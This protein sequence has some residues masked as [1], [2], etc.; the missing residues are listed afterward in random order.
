MIDLILKGLYLCCKVDSKY[1]KSSQYIE[2]TFPGKIFAFDMIE[3]KKDM[4][5]I[6]AINYFSRFVFAKVLNLKYLKK[7]LAFIKEV[8]QNI[9]FKKLI[10]DNGKEFNNSRLKKWSRENDVKLE[11]SIPYYHQSNGR[12][13]RVNRT[14]RDGMKKER[15]EMKLDLKRFLIFIITL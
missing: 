2:T 12:V 7:V 15:G 4:R 14:I 13:Q 6:V 1:I 9:E 10:T 11:F 5:I 8:Y 3:I